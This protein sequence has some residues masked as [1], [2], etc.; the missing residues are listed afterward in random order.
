MIKRIKTYS[1]NCNLPLFKGSLI[2]EANTAK[3]AYDK[4]C[5]M[6]APWRPNKSGI[7]VV[8]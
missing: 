5:K 8:K 1:V 3:E 7:R 6:I 4:A 2:V